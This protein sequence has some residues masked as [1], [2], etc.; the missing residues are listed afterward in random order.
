M[1]NLVWAGSPQ[2]DQTAGGIRVI[3]T[4]A[5]AELLLADIARSG[6]VVGIDCETEGV[7]PSEE[8][9]VGK[10]RIICWSLAWYPAESIGKHSIWGHELAARAFI[11]NWGTY[12]QSLL[13]GVFRP[14]LESEHPK[15]GH[16]VTSFDQHVFA[17]HGIRL[18][19]V[20]GDTLRRSKLLTSSK[21]VKHG[22]KD[23]MYLRFGYAAGEF[24]RL[25]SRPKRLKSKR[26]KDGRVASCFSQKKRELIPLSEIPRRYP[27][28]LTT[29]ID[30]ASLDAKATLELYSWQEE[31]LTKQPARGGTL[32]DVHDK[33]WHPMLQVLNRCERTGFRVN[34]DLAREKAERAEVVQLEYAD[35][36]REWNSTLENWGS[37]DQ[38]APFL[39]DQ[40][41]LPVPPIAGTVKAI[42]KAE[43]GKR[44]TAEASLYWLE[45]W[46]N[47]HRE[48][49]IAIGLRNLRGWRKTTRI[50]QDLRK[51]PKLV[52]ANGR[53]HAMLAPETDTGRLSCRK[54]NL[55]AIAGKDPFRLREIFEASPGHRLIVADYSQLEVYILAHVLK[56][57]LGDDSLEKALQGDVYGVVAKTIWPEKLQGIEPTDIKHHPEKGIR[58]LRDHAK[59]TVLSANY[60][61]GP[62]GLA[63]SLLDETGEVRPVE[64]GQQLLDGYFRTFPIREAQ[65]WFAAYARQHGYVA[66]LLGRRRPLPESRSTKPSRAASG[67]RKA[68]NSPIQGG[69]ADIVAGA[70]VRLHQSSAFRAFGAELVLQVHDE[71]V[72]ECPEATAEQAAAAVKWVMEDDYG[73]KVGLKAEV[74]VCNNWAEG[75]Q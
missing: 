51:L 47:K 48:T 75:K 43:P 10:G 40:L 63:L 55:Q 32:K 6:S 37:Y 49:E 44:P 11:P 4:P 61:K 42:K 52:D 70:M 64:Y 56:V 57:L 18:G 27:Q 73:L 59:I 71:L 38:L 35:N 50:L 41:K 69:A 66:T 26:W 20:R 36:L 62:E 24:E 60:C 34:V 1:S 65:Q 17:N 46:A 22:L 12:E 53:I 2:T 23:L 45:L 7:D 67:D 39:Y 21:E 29:L 28:R 14:F 25:F 15:V 19:G 74:T 72:F 68:A 16:N 33:V 30:Y 31:Q 13:Q 3:L 9:A 5:D 54:P 8:S 58:E